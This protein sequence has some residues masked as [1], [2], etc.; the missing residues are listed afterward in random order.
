MIATIQSY[1]LASLLVAFVAGS[2]CGVFVLCLFRFAGSDG[3]PE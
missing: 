3:Q 2:W 1:P